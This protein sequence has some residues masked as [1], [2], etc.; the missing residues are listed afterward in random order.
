VSVLR[1]AGFILARQDGRHDVYTGRTYGS[2]RAVPV[3][4]SYDEYSGDVLKSMIKQSGLNKR[5]FYALDPVSAKKLNCR[6]MKEG[7]PANVTA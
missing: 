7:L 4:R 5:E 3:P 6:F 1:A 2:N